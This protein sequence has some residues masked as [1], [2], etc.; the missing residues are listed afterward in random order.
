MHIHIHKAVHLNVIFKSRNGSRESYLPS[1]KGMY[2][3]IP[4]YIELKLE[5]N[6]V[7]C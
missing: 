5:G 4:T 3:Y 2:V 7:T 1:D 6:T